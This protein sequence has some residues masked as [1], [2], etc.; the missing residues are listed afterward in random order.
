MHKSACHGYG[1]LRPIVQQLVLVL[2]I[3]IEDRTHTMMMQLRHGQQTIPCRRGAPSFTAAGAAA[4]RPVLVLGAAARSR[5]RKPQP[6]SVC[7]G[8]GASG[9]SPASASPAR[10]V[11]DTALG[12]SAAAAVQVGGKLLLQNFAGADNT[13]LRLS[14]QLVSATVAGS[15]G[16]GVK[17]DAAVLDAVVGS[18]EAELDVS[19]AWD[20]TLGAPGAVVVKNHSDFPVYLKLLSVPAGFGA[21]KAAVHFACNG[22]VYPVDKHPYRLFFTNDACVK[23]ETP[24]A[25]LKYREDELSL[26]RGEGE[27]ADR[28]FQPWD[29]VYDYALY[30][31]LGNPDLRKDL[32]RPVMGGSQEYP[33]PRRLKTGRPA[34]K[35][36]PR[37]ETRAPLDEDIYVP[38][39]E[40]V[41]YGSVPAPTLPPR[42]G[43]FGSLADVYKLYGLDDLGRLPDAKAIINSNAPF[44]IAPRVISVNPTNWRKDEEFARQMIAGANPVCIKR[45]TKFP[46]ASELDRSVYGDQD[47]KINRDHVERNMCGMTVQQ[48][49]DEGRLYVVDHHDWVMPYLKR[50]NE[51]P[52]EEEKAEISQRKVYAARTL[53]FLNHDDSTLKPLAIELSSPHPENEKLG[54]VS[55]VYTPPDTEDITAGSFSAWEVAKAHAAAN[56]TVENNFVTHWLNTHA[57]MEPIVIAANR[58]MSVLHPIHRL[59]KPH[60]RKTLHINAVARQI[61]VGSGDLRKN[62]SIFRGIHE[63]TYFPSK[64]NMEMS[65]KAYKAWNFTEL[66]LP[67]DLIKRGVAR[68]DPKKPEELELLIKD[69]PYAV[70]GLEMWAAIKKWVTDY[71]AIYYADDGAVARDSELQA[72]WREVRD[73]GHGDLSGA[74]WWLA[75][76]TLADLVEACTTV[77]WLGSAYHAA[78]SFGQYDYQGFVPN[79]PSLTTSPVPEA[80]KEVTESE[81]LGSITPVTEA[82]GFMSISSGPMALA[83]SGEVYLGQRPDTEQWTSEQSAA[84]ALA[85]FRG[86]LKQVAENIERRNADPELKN[87]TGPVEAPYT[88]FKPTAQP[89]PV[90]RGIPNS[91]TV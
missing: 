76:D 90:I 13:Q 47:S 60:F 78:I 26:L 51:L 52:G 80:G 62:G 83:S 30:N 17:A 53:L 27:S 49:M 56:D 10:A 89:G 36:D 34:A 42:G 72:W 39:D 24:S 9:K 45:V 54:A 87:R 67:N 61:V 6:A 86:R 21:D 19:L 32:A 84:A 69:Y 77:V 66:A 28:A 35:T 79:G 38:C 85:E 68:G 81:F 3:T 18:G 31:D 75:M 1:T 11:T 8:Q 88:L 50:I 71:C 5:P 29:R 23:E 20:E 91:I 14:I 44:P 55:A 46:L 2:S 65:S 25:L 64:Y 63:F 41:G 12:A 59:L 40:R 7:L 43:H 48:A 33:Y 22:W 37:T 74:P 16:R 82:L 4:A 15:D 70:D 57:F 73:V 58:Q